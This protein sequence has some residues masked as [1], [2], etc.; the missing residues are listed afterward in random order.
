MVVKETHR[1]LVPHSLTKHAALAR[2]QAATPKSLSSSTNASPSAIKAAAKSA[3]MQLARQMAAEEEGSDEE[4]APENYFSLGESSQPPLLVSKD[5]VVPAGV[6]L[7]PGT[8]NAPLQFGARL[9]G[10]SGEGADFDVK[11]QDAAYQ[12]YQDPAGEPGSEPTSEVRNG[13]FPTMNM[14]HISV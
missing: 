3:A 9:P 1:P 13:S 14:C 7:P 10:Y 11:Q 12:Q 6:P 4:L 8:E 2:T 5:G